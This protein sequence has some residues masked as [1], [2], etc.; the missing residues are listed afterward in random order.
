MSTFVLTYKAPL[1]QAGLLFVIMSYMDTSISLSKSE[2][3][4]SKSDDLSED[5]VVLF[6]PGISGKAFSDRFQSV[7]AIS[8]KTGYPIA[9][10]NAWESEEDV[11]QKTYSYYQQAITEAIEYLQTLGYNSVI[12]IGKSFGGGLLLSLHHDAIVKKILWAPALGFA[13]VSTI[14]KMK[15]EPLSHIENLKDI[16]LSLDFISS[17]RA[18]L[19]FIHGTADT[20]IPISTSRAFVSANSNARIIEID[21]AD[22]SFKTP[23]SELSLNEATEQFLST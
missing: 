13:E 22:H 18:T 9:R 4:L 7:V 3:L 2:L 11:Q 15:D 1:T 14:E 16:K 20:A 23:E 6:L 19:C 5:T 8:L 12:A 10:M 21:G 17:D